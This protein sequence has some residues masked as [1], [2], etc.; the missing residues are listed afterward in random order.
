ML[1]EPLR[2]YVITVDNNSNIEQEKTSSN[3]SIEDNINT[4]QITNEPIQ[5]NDNN[6]VA[7]DTNPSP[8]DVGT[9]NNNH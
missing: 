3:G 6:F 5:D 1:P 8:I 7:P 2:E 4:K 9:S